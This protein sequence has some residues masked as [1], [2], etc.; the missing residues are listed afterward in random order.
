MRRTLVLAAAATLALAAIARADDW[1]HEYP[2]AASTPIRLITGDAHV[3]VQPGRPGAVRMHVHTNG[4]T[5]GH[6]VVID[7]R[8]EAGAWVA[9]VRE[10]PHWISF[11]IS[12]N[13]R[14]IVIDLTVPPQ[15]PLNVSTGDGTIEAQSLAGDIHLHTGDG[16]IHAHA[17]KG[18]LALDTG[19]GGIHAD[20]LDG[21]VSAHSGDGRM[22]LDGRFDRLDVVSGDG[23]VAVTALPG[24]RV[25]QDWNVRTGDGSVT[26]R[27]PRDLKAELDAH[28]GDGGI[29]LDIPVQVS[30]GVRHNTVH[31]TINGGGGLIRLHT[32]DGGIHIGAS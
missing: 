15:G 21:L 31:G 28:T 6:H 3:N 17:L 12:F 32:G 10:R 9:E 20:G 4:L 30:G 18:E 22:Q 2:I 29:D 7:V 27:L 8:N 25:T 23:P 24:S 14:R 11:N 16:G 13:S 19:D 1:E 5:I 26:L